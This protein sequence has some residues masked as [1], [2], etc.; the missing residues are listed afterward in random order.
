MYRKCHF[1]TRV[2]F[3]RNGNQLYVTTLVIQINQA[4][5]EN[6]ISQALQNNHIMAIARINF[7]RECIENAILIHGLNLSE[8]AINCT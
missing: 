3:V 1:E 6:Q 2:K 7:E 8:T 4:T 5:S